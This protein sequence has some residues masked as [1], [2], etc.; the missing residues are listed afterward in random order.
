MPGLWSCLSD[1]TLQAGACLSLSATADLA[2]AEP[3]TTALT[4]LP[5]P[6]S[7]PEPQL[8]FRDMLNDKVTEQVAP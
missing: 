5:I 6:S 3:H 7:S 4:S 2:V 8:A 1:T